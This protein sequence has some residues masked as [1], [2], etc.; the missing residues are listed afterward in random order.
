MSGSGQLPPFEP[1]AALVATLER[2]G[3]ACALGGS[4]LL[5]ALGLADQVNDWDLQTDA[6][7]DAVRVALSDR[8]AILKGRD[9]LHADHKLTLP[10]ARIEVICRFAFEVP[11]GVVHLPPCPDGGWRGIPLAGAEVWAIAYSLLAEGEGSARRRER[12]ERLFEH[13]ARRGART[14]VCRALR[15]E[16]LPAALAARLDALPRRVS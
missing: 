5:H 15:A 9:T 4:G 11:G 7:H 16:P 12:A 1:L 3:I 8:Q 14:D 6:T 13:L 10:D 2:A